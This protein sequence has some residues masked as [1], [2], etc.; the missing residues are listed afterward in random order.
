MK[1]GLAILLTVC[2][3]AVMVF[4]LT[5]CSS[6]EP[7]IEDTSNDPEVTIKF[8]SGR[9]LNHDWA[10][11]AEAFK[12]A[13]EETSGGKITVE[14][15]FAMQKTEDE[16]A[17]MTKS[18]ELDMTIGTLNGFSKLVPQLGYVS[19]PCFI[20]SFEKADE[21][22]YGDGDSA[23]VGAGIRDQI[24]ASGVHW[25]GT[26]DAE[27]HWMSASTKKIES[28]ADLAGL[29]I[30]IPDSSALQKFYEALGAKPVKMGLSK[31]ASALQ[32]G[33]ISGQDSGLFTAYSRSFSLFDKYWT[34]T[35]HSYE[36]AV[37]IMSDACWTKLSE[38]QQN[39]L[40]QAAAD[41]T[42]TVNGTFRAA[43][44]AIP[45]LLVNEDGCEVIEVSESFQAELLAAAQTVWS[46]PDIAASCDP[47]ALAKITS[48]A[49]AG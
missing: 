37:M 35:N 44:S 19:L 27:M 17:S 15:S 36:A 31:V 21:L 5:G 39:I 48:G 26:C 9:A 13:V 12:A 11:A 34:K 46:D 25:L 40:L 1:K 43:I 29:T 24:N 7:A 49:S 32:L 18:G 10:K 14:L 41:Y 2:M 28:K 6:G 23:W 4:S 47:D 38:N 22:I 30:R 20:D 33:E 3:M 16:L 45:D 8:G 42:E